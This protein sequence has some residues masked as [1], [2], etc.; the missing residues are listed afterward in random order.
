MPESRAPDLTPDEG[1]AR[2][3]PEPGADLPAIGV[4]GDFIDRVAFLANSSVSLVTCVGY[5]EDGDPTLVPFVDVTLVAEEEEASR[6]V[7]LSELISLDN[8]TGLLSDLSVDMRSACRELNVLA[9]GSVTVEPARLT[10]MRTAL[11]HMI[12]QVQGCIEDL[13]AIASGPEAG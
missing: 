3:R 11:S 12:E 8:M 9:R 13:D 1:A 10:S 6:R 7:V 4:R 2:Q 5:I